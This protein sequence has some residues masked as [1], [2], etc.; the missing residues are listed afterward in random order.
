MKILRCLVGC[1]V[2]FSALALT[3]ALAQQESPDAFSI[4]LVGTFDYPGTGNQTRPQKIN[5]KGDVVGIYVD[6]SVVSR[7][8]IMFRNGNFS[9][10][11]VDPN[12]TGSN[13]EGRG[14]NNS[15]LACGD[16]LDG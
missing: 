16:Y 10:P 14:I 7:G 2:G 15:G 6:A 5:D 9:P 4:E 3:G 13:T 1:A 8:F 12:D 11:L